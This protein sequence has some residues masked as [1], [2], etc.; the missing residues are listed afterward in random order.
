MELNFQIQVMSVVLLVM[1]VSKW[2]K[3]MGLENLSSP[4]ADHQKTHGSNGQ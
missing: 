4:F 3:I 1:K 2:E